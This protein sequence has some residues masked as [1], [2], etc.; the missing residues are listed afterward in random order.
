MKILL[1]Q[2][3]TN[4]IEQ[5]YG[6]K[7]KVNFGHAPSLALGYIAAYLEKDGHKVAIL[8]ASAMELGI[9]ETLK[10]IESFRPELVGLT[11]LTNYANS[12]KILAQRIKEKMPEIITVLG[13]PHATYFHQEILKEM[14]GIDHVIYGEA[15]TVIRDYVRFL[16]DPKNLH[17]LKSLV[18]RDEKGKAVVNPPTEMVIK[19][20]EIPMPAWH[21]YDMSLYRPLPRQYKRQP[22]F[23]MITSRGCWWHRCKFCFQAGHNA[24]KFR[25]QSPERVVSEIEILYHKYGIREIAFWDDTFIMQRGWL[26]KFKE[27]LKQKKLDISWTASG[28]V[29]TMSEE[30]IRTIYEAGCWSMFIGVESGNQ[31]LLDTIDK[32]I[33]LE[34]TREIFKIANKI[35]IETRGAFMLGLPGET[36]EMGRKTIDF[37]IEIDPTYAIFYATHPRYGTELYD[38]AV[39]YGKFLDEEFRGMSKVTYVPEG[40]K[41]AQELA[42]I[43]RSA[44]RKFYLRPRFIWKLLR[45]IRNLSD[46]IEL[47]KG[48]LLFLGLSNTKS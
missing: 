17:K 13:G 40:Y 3:P 7:Q 1:I 33:T 42:T 11:V 39:S 44:Y 8:D 22:F 20:D 19:L 14:P 12:A 23:T 15:D 41:D 21:L 4:F 37:A 45:R 27:L 32:G 31:N 30:I 34:K 43:V 38:I 46:V 18:Y 10:H 25:R 47:L 26:R 6:V 35:G 5:A 16:G 28:K 24:V 29:N 36:P 9:D 2:P 48:F